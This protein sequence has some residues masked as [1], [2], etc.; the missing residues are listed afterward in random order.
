MV[1]LLLVYLG[2]VEQGEHEGAEPYDQTAA[3]EYPYR[4]HTQFLWCSHDLSGRRSKWP[5][6]SKPLREGGGQPLALTIWSMD[7]VYLHSPTFWRASV[8]VQCLQR[9]HVG[10][11]A[12]SLGMR[13][14]LGDRQAEDEQATARG[15]LDDQVPS[16]VVGLSPSRE[17]E[18]EDHQ[19]QSPEAH[20]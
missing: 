16:V 20:Q 14:V 15:S 13:G 11:F 7:P 10:R 5:Q 2:D 12:K 9:K 19:G 4:G 1:A 6:W 8:P 18:A 3:D 17:A